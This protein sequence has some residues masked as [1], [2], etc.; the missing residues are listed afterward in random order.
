MAWFGAQESGCNKLSPWGQFAAANRKSKLCTT[1]LRTSRSIS[2]VPQRSCFSQQVRSRASNSL[3]MSPPNAHFQSA[4]LDAC[5]PQPDPIIN[6]RASE[7]QCKD[8]RAATLFGR[9]VVIS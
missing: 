6:K 4:R 5:S 2:L 1:M 9:G 8:I 3:V 7:L